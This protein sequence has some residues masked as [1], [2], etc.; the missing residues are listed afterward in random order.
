MDDFELL[1][2]YLDNLLPAEQ[3]AALEARL[4]AE[5]A[6]AQQLANLRTLAEVLRA[7]PLHIP[8][9]DF[10]LDVSKYRRATPYWARYGAM[11]VFGMVGGAAAALLLFFGLLSSI[12]N[13]PTPVQPNTG[14]A[15]A[16]N[17]TATA[18]LLAPSVRLAVTASITASKPTEAAALPTI[19]I[20]FSAVMPSAPP[21]T[22]N[23]AMAADASASGAGG[24]VPP[25]P[26]MNPYD[27]GEDY[28]D[29][30]SAPIATMAL[31]PQPTLG[32][33]SG[34][35]LGTATAPRT[36]VAAQMATSIPTSVAPAAAQFAS[37]PPTG[38]AVTA[39]AESFATTIATTATPA[40]AAA[41]TG[42]AEG[43]SLSAR[44]ALVLGLAL[45]MVSAV[46]WLLAWSRRRL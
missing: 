4:A 29:G 11:Q 10:R 25:A 43:V 18:T 15:I 22:A 7:A 37:P 14:D 26:L 16:I 27:L 21:P 5:P 46:V 3:K 42:S 44:V 36:Q 9:R 24:A 45:L 19:T 35:V 32:K 40:N 6:L 41:R 31:V 30:L 1:S 39:V 13:N 33:A 8:P 34:N 23:E 17:P 20:V 2:A 28:Q 12:N 38:E